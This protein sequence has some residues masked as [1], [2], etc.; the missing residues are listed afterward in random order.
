VRNLKEDYAECD[1]ERTRGWV[2][3]A[4]RD[5]GIRKDEGACWFVSV[6]QG[7]DHDTV[8]L[9]RSPTDAIHYASMHAGDAPRNGT[10]RWTLEVYGDGENPPKYLRVHPILD[11][12]GYN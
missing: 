6:E 4:R 9:S 2:Y 11:E 7:D 3:R 8:W 12:D 5:K 1:D 10:G